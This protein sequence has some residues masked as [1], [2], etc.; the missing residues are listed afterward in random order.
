MLSVTVNKNDAGQRADKF[1]QKT[2]RDIPMSLLYK[3][4]RTKKIK[5]NRKRIAPNDMLCEGDVLD[6]YI[7]EEF[8]PSSEKKTE[9]FTVLTPHIDVVYEDGNML[10]VNKRPG[11]SCVP[12]EREETNTLI[13]HIKAYLYRKG[14]YDPANENSFAPALCNRIDRNTAGI[15]IAAK[16]AETLR[17]INEDIRER[18]IKKKYLCV[19]HGI[20]EKREALLE[21]WLIKDSD[22]NTVTVY[23]RKPGSRAARTIKTGYKVLKSDKKCDISLLEVELHTGRTH[24]IRAHL[25]SIGH[26][27]YGDGKYGINKEDRKQ[28]YKYQALCSYSTT[29][30]GKTYSIPKNEIWFVTELFGDVK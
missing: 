20:P 8:Y 11:M 1:L 21:G 16:N 12:D 30:D 2:L 3:Y 23:D 15:V 27:L 4:L 6:M 5:C 28:G 26:P 24:Q 29:I 7:P 25:A 10:L 22:T 14:E 13:N 19:V 9:A 18:R 17:K